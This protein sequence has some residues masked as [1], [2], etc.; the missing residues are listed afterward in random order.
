MSS[1]QKRPTSTRFT[2]R[3]ALRLAGGAGAAAMFANSRQSGVVAAAAQDASGQITIPDS[4]AQLP[5]E[6]V[7]FRWI[8]SG[9][10]KAIYYNQ[11]FAAYQQKHPNITIQYDPLPWAEIGQIVPLGVQ[12]GEAHDVFA[13]PMEIPAAQ[14]VRDGWVAPLDDIIPNFAAWKERFPIGSFLDGVHV[15]NGKT[16]TFPVT[17]DKRYGTLTLYNPTYLQQAGYDF[18]AKPPTWDDF[19]NA[20]KKMTEQGGGQY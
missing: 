7:T 17:S 14:A 13:M 18:E 19:R 11:L 16:Y 10:L 5:T 8:D 15:F 3:D 1:N 4:G 2:R 12:N 6:E 20:A 9:D